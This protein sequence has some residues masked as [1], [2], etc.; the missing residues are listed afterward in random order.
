VAIGRL[1]DGMRVIRSGLA[2]TERI[3]VNGVQRARPGAA[4]TPHTVNLELATSAPAAD[5]PASSPDS[6]SH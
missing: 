5:S 3:V 1:I 4:I 2:G 6:D